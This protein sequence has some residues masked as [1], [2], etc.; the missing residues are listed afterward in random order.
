MMLTKTAVKHTDTAIV[1]SGS[2]SI[3]TE[4]IVL[5]TDVGARTTSGA[6]QSIMANQTTDSTVWVGAVVKFINFIIEAAIRPGEASAGSNNSIGWCEWAL[7][8]VKETETS[9]PITNIGTTHLGDIANKMFR[10]ECI[11]SGTI[12]MSRTNP[13]STQLAFK[14]PKAKQVIR[15]GDEWRLYTY[16]RDVLAVAAGTDTARIV[17]YTNFKSYQ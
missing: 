15:P 16:Y 12:P 13:N 4:S 5:D 3:P 14:V 7:V 10:N 11:Y 2:G 6:T 1:T 8:M 9:I 17:I